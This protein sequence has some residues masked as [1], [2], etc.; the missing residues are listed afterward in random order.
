MLLFSFVVL[1][2]Y[3]QENPTRNR[4]NNMLWAGYYNALEFNSK[5]S[6][7]T[8]IQIRTTNWQEELSQGL[9]RSG[10]SYKINERL[11]LTNGFA[12]FN[13]FIDNSTGRNEYRPWQEIGINDKIWKF[14]LSHR[15]RLEERINQKFKNDLPN[16]DYTFNFRF[17]YKFD[18]KFPLK[19]EV[20]KGNNV[21]LIAGNELM[22]NC[23]KEIGSNFFDQNRTSAGIHFELNDKLDIQF[24]YLRIWQQL[25]NGQTINNTNVLRFNIYHKINL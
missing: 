25:S 6:L 21:Y 3:T 13:Y 11:N 2:F 10:L 9:I 8:D 17:R 20:E 12:Y 15:Y 7:V 4:Y 23:G 24:Q 1:S 16:D 22:V 5:W 14:K 18:L 19:K